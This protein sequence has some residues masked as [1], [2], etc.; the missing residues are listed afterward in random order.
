MPKVA[1]DAYARYMSKVSLAQ[2]VGYSNQAIIDEL[3]RE[4][5]TITPR[6]IMKQAT[7]T[8]D[9]NPYKKREAARAAHECIVAIDRIV[10]EL[11]K[12]IPV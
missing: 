8:M 4:R 3:L 5:A 9:R 10:K 1:E 7:L 12:E 6:C 11:E 2:K